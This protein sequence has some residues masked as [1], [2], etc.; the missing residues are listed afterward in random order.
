M[1]TFKLFATALVMAGSLLISPSLVAHNTGHE[2]RTTAG[3]V[4]LPGT[5]KTGER[6]GCLACI[7]R[8]RGK[9][10][11]HYHPDY[12]AGSRCRPDNGKP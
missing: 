6:G 7:E 2:I 8:N 11:M 10:K 4:K 9:D 12:P 1:K 5:A 3:C